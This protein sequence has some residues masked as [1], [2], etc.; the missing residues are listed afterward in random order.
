MTGFAY[1][2][3]GL[4]IKGKGIAESLGV[5]QSNIYL[6]RSGEQEIPE[7]HLEKLESFIGVERK[8]LK[9]KY[10]T[11]EEKKEVDGLLI[12]IELESLF[13]NCDISLTGVSSEILNL[14]KMI[15]A[16]ISI[17]EKIKSNKYLLNN[18]NYGFSVS[19]NAENVLK[20]LKYISENESKTAE[21]LINDIITKWEG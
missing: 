11:E 17:Y 1:I 12:V 8:W 3:N 9:K 13:N 14:S 10:L 7:K 20:I 2:L 15:S 19:L 5:S 16:Q 4:N 6:W 21:E 18:V